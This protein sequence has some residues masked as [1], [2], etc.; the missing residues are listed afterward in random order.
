VRCRGRE[1]EGSI[2]RQAKEEVDLGMVLAALL[3]A[4]AAA[5]CVLYILFGRGWNLV[6]FEWSEDWNGHSLL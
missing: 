4:T 6:V 3:P 2:L 1:G 5:T